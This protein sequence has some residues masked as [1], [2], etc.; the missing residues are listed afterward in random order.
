M[1]GPVLDLV[2]VSSYI[3][4]VPFA[5]IC[6]LF[7]THSHSANRLSHVRF[8]VHYVVHSK[9]LVHNTYYETYKYKL[10]DTHSYPGASTTIFNSDFSVVIILMVTLQLLSPLEPFFTQVTSVS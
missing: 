6:V 3:A 10:Q 7:F 9:S 8:S 4:V 2:E 5:F 1:K